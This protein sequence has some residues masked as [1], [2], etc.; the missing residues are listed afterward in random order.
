MLICQQPGGNNPRSRFL[1]LPGEIRNQIYSYIIY[2]ELEVVTVANCIKAEHLGASALNLPIF[3]VC[4]QVRMEALS[5]LCATKVIRILCVDAAT[6]FF[7]V[8]G[9]TIG[10]IKFFTLVQPARMITPDYQKCV[11]RFF[12][13]LGEEATALKLFR[14]EWLDKAIHIAESAEHEEFMKHV[15]KLGE[16]RSVEIQLL[17]TKKRIARYT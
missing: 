6:T 16:E 3:R 4:R 17:E 13:I 11:N 14:L 8:I 12:D 1:Q 10:E 15:H 5:Y 7:E 9:G 2:S